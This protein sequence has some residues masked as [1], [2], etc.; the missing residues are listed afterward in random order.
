MMLRQLPGS[1]D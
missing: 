1:A